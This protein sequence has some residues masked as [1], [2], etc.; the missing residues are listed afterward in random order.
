[1]PRTMS[2]QIIYVNERDQSLIFLKI[3]I[4]LKFQKTYN[5]YT[6]ITLW[7]VPVHHFFG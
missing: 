2:R 5:I 1:M 3:E 6:P 4:S 7:S